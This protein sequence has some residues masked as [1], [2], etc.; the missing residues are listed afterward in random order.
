MLGQIINLPTMDSDGV[1]YGFDNNVYYFTD[2]DSNKN[3]YLDIGVEIDFT[4][5]NQDSNF[6][7]KLKKLHS[8]VKINSSS[9]KPL[10]IEDSQIFITNE[11]DPKDLN[12]LESIKSYRIYG[13]SIS[14]EQALQEIVQAAKACGANAVIDVKL[15]ITFNPVKSFLLYR[16]SGILALA[17]RIEDES[18]ATNIIPPKPIQINNQLLKKGSPNDTTK[19]KIRMLMIVFVLLFMPLWGQLLLDYRNHISPV[20]SVP[21][22]IFVL[23]SAFIIYIN[24]NP[25]TNCGYMIRKSTKS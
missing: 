24:V 5:K 3:T 17:S 8:Y 11:K 2:E 10:N 14:K 7:S 16:Y 22:G 23:V 19:N 13:E 12:I 21:L 20:I 18:L 4:P 25:H 9:Y 15:D 6:I 1:I